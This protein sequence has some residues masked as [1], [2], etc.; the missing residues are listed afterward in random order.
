[1]HIKFK[2]IGG[3]LALHFLMSAVL[4]SADVVLPSGDDSEIYSV[5]A[6]V[7]GDPICLN[8]VLLESRTEEMPLYAVY[9]GDELFTAVRNV[10]RKI[11]D[12]LI[13]RKLIVNDYNKN[14]FDIPPQYLEDVLDS[15]SENYGV[16]S[17]KD[18]AG[19][20]HLA[21]L[22]ISKLRTR[23]HERL[24]EHA[25][26][27]RCRQ[28]IVHV[29]PQAVFSYFARNRDSFTSHEQWEIGMIHIERNVANREKIL[30]ALA[31]NL[32]REPDSF[33]NLAIKYSSGPNA[34]KG[35]ILGLLEKKR[36]RPEFFA[37]LEGVTEGKVVGP[38]SIPDGDYFLR[39]IKVVPAQEKDFSQVESTIREELEDMER[40]RAVSNYCAKLRADAVI[41]IY[42]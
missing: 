8:D 26:L 25:M 32:G 10:R 20:L 3:V 21:G 40:Q 31:E 15:M 28:V 6:S 37:A 5:V 33:S 22:E 9:S 14:P 17:R 13:D 23:L 16:R 4:H 2:F 1:M 19:Q 42:L 38:I 7:D 24:I 36:I 41:Q 12:K 35:G 34:A 29:T 30:E 27:T 18:L 39:L 11:L